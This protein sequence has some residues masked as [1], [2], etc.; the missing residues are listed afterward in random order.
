MF[1]LGG[2]PREVN[3]YP[4]FLIKVNAT[5]KSMTQSKLPGL[6]HSPSEPDTVNFFIVDTNV[7]A[8]DRL[9]CLR[10]RQQVS[11]SINFS[12]SRIGHAARRCLKAPHRQLCL[13]KY[14]CLNLRPTVSPRQENS[15]CH[16]VPIFPDQ[17]K[18]PTHQV[19]I[20]PDH[21]EGPT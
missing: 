17:N 21:N 15:K 8:R 3:R 20:F 7:G 16:Q 10:E 13:G 5:P 11:Q 14:Y 12:S 4:T 9:F 6:T 19:P 2:T 1:R 18:G